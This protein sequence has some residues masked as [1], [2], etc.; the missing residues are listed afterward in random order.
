MVSGEAELAWNEEVQ[1]P[2]YVEGD[3][4][5]LELRDDDGE[6]RRPL[7]RAPAPGGVGVACRSS[8]V[9][10]PA[11]AYSGRARAQVCASGMV[12]YS[13][14]R[15][16]LGFSGDVPV[17]MDKQ[18]RES[19]EG[20]RPRWLPRHR[21]SAM[22]RRAMGDGP[23]RQC[24]RGRWAM[25]SNADE[26]LRRGPLMTDDVDNGED[27]ATSEDGRPTA[28]TMVDDDEDDEGNR[29]GRWTMDDDDDDDASGR[30]TGTTNTTTG[31]D[32]G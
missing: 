5:V 14:I 19:G 12:P 3:A 15:R 16:P 25:D 28:T 13:S 26:G 23:Q 18:R 27:D 17:V 31:D 7:G 2:C 9:G 1:L 32:S 22:Q 8:S 4:L 20:H 10:R 11:S 6:A 30:W 24:P 29:Q 21:G